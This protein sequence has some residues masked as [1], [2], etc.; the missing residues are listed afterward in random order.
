MA[1]EEDLYE[2]DA[3]IDQSEMENDADFQQ[4]LKTSSGKRPTVRCPFFCHSL[5][6]LQSALFFVFVP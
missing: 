3:S 1:E 6:Q 2:F 5:F 4:A